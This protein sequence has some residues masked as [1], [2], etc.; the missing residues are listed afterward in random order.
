MANGPQSQESSA[1]PFIGE[2]TASDLIAEAPRQFERPSLLEDID[3]RVL[4]ERRRQEAQEVLAAASAVLGRSLDLRETAEAIARAAIP[5]FADCAVVE[6]LD[7]HGRLARLALALGDP[8]L[9]T[10]AD[11]VS[12][13]WPRGRDGGSA[14][15]GLRDR[16]ADAPERGLHLERNS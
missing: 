13:W 11:A 14:T 6:A 15:R 7:Q 16:R 1:R 8:P 12:P 2:V 4:E 3:F 9:L 10:A 5:H